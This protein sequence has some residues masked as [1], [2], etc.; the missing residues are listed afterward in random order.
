[1]IKTISIRTKPGEKS[2]GILRVQ[3]ATFPCALGRSGIGGLKKEGD[4]KTPVI[5][6][7]AL[8]GFYRSD[9]QKRPQSPLTFQPITPSLGWCDDPASPLYNRAVHLPFQGS[10]EKTWRDDHLYDLV[11][12]LDINYKKRKKGAGSALFFHI[13]REDFSATEGC[14]AVS[15]PVMRHLLRR[16]NRH[17]RFDIIAPGT[18]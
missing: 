10:C 16:I 14:I 7:H 5:R 9:R 6:C 17:T 2:R 3:G 12:V 4:G 13:A 1:M 18:R 8:F 11:L 15:Q